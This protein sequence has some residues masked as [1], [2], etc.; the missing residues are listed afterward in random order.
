MYLYSKS[1][2][3]ELIKFNALKN[4]VHTLFFNESQFHSVYTKLLKQN[5]LKFDFTC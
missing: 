2:Y 3:I 1:E 4:S 5:T